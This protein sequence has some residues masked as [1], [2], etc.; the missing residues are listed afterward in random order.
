MSTETSNWS[1]IIELVSR[2][3]GIPKAVF[4]EALEDLWSNEPRRA[5]LIAAGLVRA[6][7]FSPWNVASVYAGLYHDVAQRSRV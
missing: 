6:E 3:K 4:I 5:I 1:E 2:E 7:D